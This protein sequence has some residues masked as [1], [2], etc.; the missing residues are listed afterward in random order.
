MPV[1][2]I[3]AVAATLSGTMATPCPP[4]DV[5]ALTPATITAARRA[6]MPWVERHRRE[7]VCA[8]REVG[9]MRGL[10]ARLGAAL[11]WDLADLPAHQVGASQPWTR[12]D[13]SPSFPAAYAGRSVTPGG[14]G[15]I[16]ALISH[17]N[18]VYPP[19]ALAGMNDFERPA[20]PQ[21]EL[22]EEPSCPGK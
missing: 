8:G 21:H 19:Y 10:A 14:G 11:A 9:V 12:F 20:I 13:P 4:Q 18:T 7:S 5:A 6:A 2:E 1:L 15:A 16:G 3:L 17:W 22:N